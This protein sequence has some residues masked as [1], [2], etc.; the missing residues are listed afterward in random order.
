MTIIAVEKIAVNGYGQGGL[1]KDMYLMLSM[2][3]M[4]N[5]RRCIYSYA[6]K[7]ACSHPSDSMS[8]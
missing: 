1:V 5:L 8:K 7:L 3:V 6:I 4:W 2:E